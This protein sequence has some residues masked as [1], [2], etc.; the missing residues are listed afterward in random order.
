MIKTAIVKLLILPT[1]AGGAYLAG[2]GHVPALPSTDTT[3]PAVAAAPAPSAQAPTGGLQVIATCDDPQE[4]P[5]AAQGPAQARKAQDRARTV[6]V[7]VPQ[8]VA[9]A[10]AEQAEPRATESTPQTSTAAPAPS[11]APSA[12]QG[13]VNL[14]TATADELEALP[15][16]GK[17]TAARIIAS[18]PIAKVEDVKAMAGVT[19]PNYALFAP[20]VH[21]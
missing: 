3:P 14:N 8:A 2:G 1:V 10:P 13:G 20:K 5:R 7:Q 9:A 19:G 12:E 11:A 17:A 16:I 6:T 15:G 18:R 4:A 21:V